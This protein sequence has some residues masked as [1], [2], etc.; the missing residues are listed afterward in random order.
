MLQPQ[1]FRAHARE[2][3][4]GH[5]A[6]ALSLAGEFREVDAGAFD[7]AIERL[8]ELASWSPRDPFEQL[9]ELGVV[10]RAPTALRCA[11]R[12]PMWTLLL[13]VAVVR[14]RAHPDVVAIALTEVGRRLGWNL[15]IV[16]NAAHL[17]VGHTS[18]ERPI[19]LDPCSG[20]LCDA[21]SL[22]C[23]L[24]WR[25]S[26]QTCAHLLTELRRRAER[27]GDLGRAIRAAEI[28]LD[29]PLDEGSAARAGRRLRRLRSRLN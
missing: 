10:A 6:L 7:A 1:P 26:H 25:C 3:C 16:G 15:G 20:E 9:R 5:A 18:F 12:G 17:Y 28:H 13:D 4:P 21:D 8:A 27:H 24:A 2:G 22:G 23:P 19:V 14:G 29:L 11:E